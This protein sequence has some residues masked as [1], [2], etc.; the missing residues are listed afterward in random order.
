MPRKVIQIAVCGGVAVSDNDS[1]SFENLYALCDNGELWVL[2][3]PAAGDRSQWHKIQPIPLKGI[4]D[5]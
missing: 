5:G 1:D 4:S 2:P 3:S